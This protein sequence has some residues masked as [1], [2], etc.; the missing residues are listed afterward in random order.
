MSLV[1]HEQR[2]DNKKNYY[3]EKKRNLTIARVPRA[4]LI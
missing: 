3:L 1:R 4:I 2:I